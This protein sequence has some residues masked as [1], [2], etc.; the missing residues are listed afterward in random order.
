M[1]ITVLESGGMDCLFGLDML[2][3]Y[4][5]AIDLKANVLRFQSLDNTPELPFLAEHELPESARLFAAGQQQGTPGKQ[6][7]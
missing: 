4:G 5:C 6:S 1:G 3:R 2:R 7:T